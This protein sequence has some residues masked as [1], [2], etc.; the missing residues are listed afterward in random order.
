MVVGRGNC[1]N[2]HC[3]EAEQRAEE[4]LGARFVAGERCSGR[5]D[6]LGIEYY[7]E[8]MVGE[9]CWKRR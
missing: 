2:V 5:I 7:E 3:S 4:D 9:R 6:L 1:R 8:V